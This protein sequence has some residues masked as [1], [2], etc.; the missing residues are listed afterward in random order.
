M[1]LGKFE[2]QLR[3]M[4]LLT[5]NRTYSIEQLCEK[6]DMSR[7]TVYRYIELFRDL[8]FEVVK[9]SGNVYRLDKSSPFFREIS[10][11][12][13]FTDDEAIT[14][15]YVLDTLADTNIQ[16]RTLR[17]KMERLYDFGIVNETEADRR[18]ADNLQ[19]LYEAIR[20]RR[21][22]VL[23][24]YSSSNSRQ[25]GDRVVEPYLFLSNNNE[26]RC[27]EPASRMNKTF[28]V[29]RIGR[30]EV[31]DLLWSHEE[32]HRPVYTDLFRFSGEERCS[33]T[34][35]LGRLAVNLLREEYPV[36]SER[37][38]PDGPE[39]WLLQTEVCSFTGVGRFILGVFEDVEVVAPEELR[40]YLCE[41]SVLLTKK[42]G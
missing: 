8:G 7:R 10:S 40:R 27:Y 29:T 21:Q 12:V 35:R 9:Q 33:V 34:L 5:Q 25:S 13:H 19:A 31:L 6:L 11:M 16:A 38:Q 32:E 39:H 23:R 15:R 1:E 28:K 22:V 4:V 36:G 24:G 37:L 26:V 3:L 17:R 41:K 42:F 14:L 20:E 18:L 30:V 2:R